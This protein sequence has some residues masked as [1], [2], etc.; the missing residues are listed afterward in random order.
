M[1]FLETE[2]LT[3]TI[4]QNMALQIDLND[5]IRATLD[6]GSGNAGYIGLSPDG[7]R[8]HVVVPV[9]GQIARG[10][11]AGNQVLEGAPFGG[12]KNWYYFYCTGYGRP[13]R[14]DE[15]IINEIRKRQAAA[16]AESLIAWAA[17]LHIEVV[18]IGL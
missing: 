4:Q 12:Y 9:D 8:Y 11:K 18:I 6:E 3:Q 15:K 16:N 5:L 14:H 2:R 17:E 10:I 1:I 7:N 13:S